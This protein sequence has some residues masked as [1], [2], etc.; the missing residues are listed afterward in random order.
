MD[1]SYSITQHPPLKRVLPHAQLLISQ[2]SIVAGAVDACLHVHRAPQQITVPNVSLDI[3]YPMDYAKIK[4][5]H[6]LL[7][8][9]LALVKIVLNVI[10]L[11]SFLPIR[12]HQLHPVLLLAQVVFTLMFIPARLV[13]P[14]ALLVLIL[15]I[16]VLYVKVDYISLVKAVLQYA[17]LGTMH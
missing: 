17:L 12:I 15:L 16:T 3:L 5:Q 8:A 1:I 4:Q 9:R 13:I 2:I 6:A 14:A 10:I 11:I 7:I